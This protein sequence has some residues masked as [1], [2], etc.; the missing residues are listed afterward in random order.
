LKWASSC[1][2]AVHPS[3]TLSG[4]EEVDACTAV[5]YDKLDGIESK[6]TNRYAT[7]DHLKSFT[8]IVCTYFG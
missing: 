8:N 5:D 3:N 6:F 7:I 4:A 2:D 1:I